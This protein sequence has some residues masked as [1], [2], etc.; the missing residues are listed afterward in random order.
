MNT[1]LR[2][3]IFSLFILPSSFSTFADEPA[4]I[5]RYL[6]DD[7]RVQH[8]TRELESTNRAIGKESYPHGAACYVW[9]C[10]NRELSLTEE[11][12]ICVIVLAPGQAACGLSAAQQDLSNNEPA[13][14]SGEA[15]SQTASANIA[16][17]ATVRET[18]TRAAEG[19][20]AYGQP[21]VCAFERCREGFVN[22]VSVGFNCW[23]EW[24]TCPSGGGGGA[25]GGGDPGGGGG[26]ASSPNSTRDGLQQSKP[27][28]CLHFSQ[29]QG[30][31]TITPKPS[32]AFPSGLSF[33]GV[34]LPPFSPDGCG[35]GN[36][37]QWLMTRGVRALYG[38]GD[39]NHPV[40]GYSFENACRQHDACYGQ[41][42]ETQN[43][44]DNRF[45]DAMN[46]T[47]N[48]DG[49]LCANHPQCRL[50]A[51]AYAG[52]VNALGGSAY[53]TAKA[54]THCAQW[55]V[56]LASNRCSLLP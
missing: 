10:E 23:P 41:F 44:C 13:P 8:L 51:G 40:P 45:F 22:G 18:L 43:S 49:V 48:S 7:D 20:I 38:I 11:E 37:Q 6:L 33:G 12:A 5:C 36:M 56:N 42:G 4:K 3:F 39:N 25:T 2:L 54:E 28:N 35:S 31:F 53:S 14:I 47:R 24:S 16:P 17:L 29:S 19:P 50:V 15:N 27:A 32:S 55:F 52:A 46:A 34:T 30:Y 26:G 21:D 1:R 9:E